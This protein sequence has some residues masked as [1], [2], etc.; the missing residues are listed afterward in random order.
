MES[1]KLLKGLFKKINSENN[2]VDEGG[3]GYTQ[4]TPH[5]ALVVSIL[6]MMV[7]DG[8]ISDQESSQLQSV[9]GK[10]ENVLKRA[11]NYVETT[12]IEQFLKDVPAVLDSQ[13]SLCVLMNVCDSI[14]AD[15]QLAEV[16]LNLFERLTSALGHS[17]KSFRSYFNTISIKNKKSVLGSFENIVESDK[18]TPQMALAASL[19]YMMSAD[20]SMA[21]EEIGQLNVVIGR[22]AVLLQAGLKY[23]KTIKFQQ[24]VKEAAAL[25]NPAQ[26]LCILTNVCDSMMSDGEVA[27]VEL[28]LF[29]RMLT[30]FNFKEEKFQPYFNILSRKNEKPVEKED[31]G[32]Q[33]GVIP[34]RIIKSEEDGVVYDR[35]L[36]R[37]EK[38]IKAPGEIDSSEDENNEISD[39]TEQSELS[40]T[41]KRKMQDNLS[42]MKQSIEGSNGIQDITDNANSRSD[43]EENLIRE[44]K[45]T[46][47]FADDKAAN[48]N[49]SVHYLD[50]D[51]SKDSVHYLNADTSK[52]SIHYL[53]TDTSKDSVHFL[54]ADA[55]K[56]SVHFL[57]NDT[58]HYASDDVSTKNS[59]AKTLTHQ[60]HNKFRIESGPVKQRTLQDNLSTISSKHRDRKK[61]SPSEQRK[62][63]DS[64]HDFD[65]SPLQVRMS[66]VKTRTDEI[67]QTLDI[68]ETVSDAH[69]T[70]R[71][72][73]LHT[74][75]FSPSPVLTQV[76]NN[77]ASSQPTVVSSPTLIVNNPILIVNNQILIIENEGFP[78]AANQSALENSASAVSIDGLKVKIATLFTALIIA[79][80]FSSFGETTTQTDLVKNMNLAANANVNLQA[81][82]VQQTMYKLAA[83]DLDSDISKKDFLSSEQQ[84]LAKSKLAT[85]LTKI[86]AQESAPASK[87]GKKE[88]TAARKHHEEL[89]AVD[90]SK[91]EWF[92]LSKAI[93]LFGI[94]LTLC[95]FF[96]RSRFI[97]YTSSLSAVA[98]TL[99]T[100]N[101][102]FLIF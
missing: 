102:Y 10:N 67:N 101:G 49:K 83:D 35:K 78:M 73:I 60:F 43:S 69:F 19:L 100:L 71:S 22:S 36:S 51:A 63:V 1:T 56:S 76:K 57:R 40:K 29:R 88:L 24:F 92:A 12:K 28:E 4:L 33:S 94:G 17:K 90:G 37:N 9:I 61:K 99:L 47:S 77:N 38:N 27:T 16:E 75:K 93:L 3:G 39:P 84:E 81:V 52:D 87:D 20:G 5:L 54:D 97:F 21:E 91:L 23:V 34:A 62:I 89:E 48:E 72:Q 96:F 50:S 42:K 82:A 85:Y 86:E 8:E 55:S 32:D 46:K 74:I 59:G 95:G 25:L 44:H 26:Q 2:F 41:I 7:A 53:D 11:L 45:D 15:G 58:A 65:K 31:E 6:Y 70:K 18:L 14:M 13:D 80:G 68:L 79:F 30:A 66:I 98:G 64:D